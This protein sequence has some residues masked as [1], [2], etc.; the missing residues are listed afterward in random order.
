MFRLLLA[1]NKVTRF[2][3][4]PFRLH[5]EKKDIIFITQVISYV[6]SHTYSMSVSVTPENFIVIIL[7]LRFQYRFIW[8]RFTDTYKRRISWLSH[9]S[10]LLDFL[11]QLLLLRYI[12]CKPLVLKTF[13]LFNYCTSCWRVCLGFRFISPESNISK[14]KNESI[15][16]EYK[17]LLI[18]ATKTWESSLIFMNSDA[19]KSDLVQVLTSLKKSEEVLYVRNEKVIHIEKWRSIFTFYPFLFRPNQ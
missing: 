9:D 8:F 3:R 7:D 18:R 6:I 1:W 17:V 10:T 13:H 15:E 14:W 4:K 5:V 2:H 12:K 16:T 19:K 11:P